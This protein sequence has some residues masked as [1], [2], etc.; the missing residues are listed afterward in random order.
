MSTEPDVIGAFGA[1]EERR[2][3]VY[4]FEQQPKELPRV[5]E[6]RFRASKGA[7]EW[8]RTQAPWYRRLCTHWVVSAKKEETRERRL[9]QLIERS[10]QHTL[11]G[12]VKKP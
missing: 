11:I 2:T 6:Q 5:Y 7:W 10:G 3:G 12:P 9:A 4:A 8:Y 1:R